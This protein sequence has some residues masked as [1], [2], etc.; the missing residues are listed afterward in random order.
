MLQRTTEDRF[1]GRV[2]SADFAGL[3]LMMSAVSYVASHLIDGGVNVRAI[4]LATGLVSLIPALLWWRAQRLWSDG[5][6]P[7]PAGAV[8]SD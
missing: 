1:R 3:F 6:T 5:R 8:Q 7:P 4:A 2:F